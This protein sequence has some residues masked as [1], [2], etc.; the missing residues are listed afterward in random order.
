[1]T[2]LV[3]WALFAILAAAFAALATVAYWELA[4]FAP[5]T[6]DG[7]PLTIYTPVVRP[8]ETL[9][10]GRHW[11]KNTDLDGIVSREF[12]DGVRYVTPVV[13]PHYP[14][15]CQDTMIAIGVPRIPPGVYRLHTSVVYQLNPLRQQTYEFW[16]T[17]FSIVARTPPLAERPP[18]GA[19]R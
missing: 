15:G 12:V 13:Q 2:K 14:R 16:S 9:T 6:A 11:C 7:T 1:M 19:P 3:N 8:G 4:P 10:Y 18:V 5:I 17:S